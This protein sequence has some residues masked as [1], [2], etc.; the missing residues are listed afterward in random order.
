MD[1]GT[2]LLQNLRKKLEG[3]VSPIQR[4]T[5]AS[6]VEFIPRD[7]G[8]FSICVAWKSGDTLCSFDRLF[9]RKEV[10]GASYA[11]GPS[12]WHVQKRACDYARDL[13]RQVLEQRGVLG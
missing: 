3:W 9:A 6:S 11:L 4:A 8:E 5:G 13:I 10:F 7:A 1:R 2:A 12:S